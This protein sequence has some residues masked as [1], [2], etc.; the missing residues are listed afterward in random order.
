VLRAEAV[1]LRRQLAD[2]PDTDLFPVLNIGS[3]TEAFRT[4]DQPWIE[5][6]VFAPLKR[7]DDRIIHTDLRSAPG[8]DIVGD[9]TD[10]GFVAELRG[11]A[12]KTLLCCNVLEHIADRD[13][14]CAAMGNLV[15]PGGYL[16]VTVP[17]AFP[18][19][20]DPIDTRYRPAPEEVASAFP[21][22]VPVRMAVVDC[23]SVATLVRHKLTAAPLALTRTALDRRRYS[24]GDVEVT[25]RGE[26]WL[27][28]ARRTFRVTCVLLRKA[29]DV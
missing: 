16:A 18:Y 9:L 19:H 29:P 11:L 23:G 5:G 22:T 20:P 3:H 2:I 7:R 26:S 13:P 21:D 8:V 15:P 10:A 6:E 24:A 17:R 1:W 14:L 25:E 28:W 4:R 27:P 12:P